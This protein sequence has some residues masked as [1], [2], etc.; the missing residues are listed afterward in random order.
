MSDLQHQR[1]AELSRELR[2]SAIPDLYSTIAQSAAAKA[3]SFA[4]FL[5]EIL[6]AER[7]ARRARAREMFARFLD[8]AF[9]LARS[10]LTAVTHQRSPGTSPGKRYCGIAV[11][12]SFPM[13]RWCSRNSAVTTAQIVW[14]P[15]S[16]GPV[17]QQPSR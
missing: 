1:L 16:S 6:R 14:L 9:S 15:R 5:E 7:D 3:A 13:L 8:R 12:R 10:Q 11:I 4:D 17:L 2:L